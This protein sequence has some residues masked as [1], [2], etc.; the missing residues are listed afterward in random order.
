M[1]D[2]TVTVT[3]KPPSSETDITEYSFPE[4]TGMALI[5]AVNH[6]IDIEVTRGTDLTAL[7]ASFSL[8]LEATASV[9]STNQESGTIVNDFSSPVTY[10]ITAGIGIK[11]FSN[12][13]LDF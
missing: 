12:Q 7:V 4:Q 3:E 6:T 9:N 1:Q 8:S 5:D 10:T 11:S 2:W 13:F